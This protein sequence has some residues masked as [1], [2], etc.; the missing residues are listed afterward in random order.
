MDA[1]ATARRAR[2]RGWCAR[3]AH[4]R[5][6]RRGQL[7]ARRRPCSRCP[8]RWL[9]WRDRCRS[10]SRR[11][12]LVSTDIRA[13]LRTV[14]ERRV[15]AP[16]RDGKVITAWNAL[17]IRAFAEAGA[18]LERADYVAV[19]SAMR[20]L[21][22]R[23]PCAR[24]RRPSH[25]ERRRGADHRIPRRRRQPRRRACSPSTRRPA[26]R[27]TSPRR[28]RSAD[29]S[30][31]SIGT[32]MATISTPLPTPSRSSCG[33]RTIDDNPVS[34]GQSVAATLFCRMHAFTGEQRWRDTP[35]RSSPH[36]R[37]WSPAHRSRSPG[38]RRRWSSWSGPMRE[39]AIVGDAD[40]AR[41]RALLDGRAAAIRPADACSRGDR[42]ATYRCS[43]AA[44]PWTASRRLCLP[45]FVCEAPVT[46]AAELEG[47]LA[48]LEPDGS[49]LTAA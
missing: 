10:T 13:R 26:S 39:I 27:D 30:S 34:A 45:G 36:S 33:P 47:Q 15:S 32:P 25:L 2:R 12:A 17:A 35:W 31:I 46:A 43:T 49:E 1:C 44:P 29:A 9:R 37:R 3:R 42:P 24:R 18:A 4:V 40:D 41:T 14:R 48:V 21:R 23:A 7:R 5:R 8:I 38:S 20:R 19:A 11:C 6:C 28:S 16:E 22:A